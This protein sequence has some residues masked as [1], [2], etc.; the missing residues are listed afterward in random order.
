MIVPCLVVVALLTGPSVLV[1]VLSTLATLLYWPSVS[2]RF[3]RVNDCCSFREKLD[4]TFS[5]DLESLCK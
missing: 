2:R 1:M 5:L 4:K 3:N